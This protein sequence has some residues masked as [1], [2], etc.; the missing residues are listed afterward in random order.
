MAQVIDV[1]QRRPTMHATFAKW[2]ALGHAAALSGCASSFHDSYLV[3]QRYFKSN[4]DTQPVI[5]LGVDDR[6][7][8]QRRVLVEPGSRVVRVQALP[9]P[10]APQETGSLKLD[11]Q[12]CFSYYIV[13]V[14]EN[15]LQAGFTTRVDY[16]EPL[17]GCTRPPEK[18]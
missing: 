5:I 3:G 10:G 8:T 17:P 7:T 1:W 13:A 4:I 12:P 2:S 18:K 6:D 14:R 11:V 9:V 15:P 16:A